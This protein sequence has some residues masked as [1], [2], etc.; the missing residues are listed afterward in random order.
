[1]LMDPGDPRGHPA[2]PSAAPDRGW[3]DR[4][5]FGLP[6]QPLGPTPRSRGPGLLCLR[7]GCEPES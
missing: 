6:A 7:K 1:M 3:G 2:L 5:S 4:W